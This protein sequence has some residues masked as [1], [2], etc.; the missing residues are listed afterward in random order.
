MK[1]NEEENTELLARCCEVI[2]APYQVLCDSGMY[3]R[4]MVQYNITYHVD[5]FS[6]FQSLYWT[7]N[8]VIA[9]VEIC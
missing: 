8:I 4:T 9:R 6:E 3:W 2:A 7:A 5:A 1:T